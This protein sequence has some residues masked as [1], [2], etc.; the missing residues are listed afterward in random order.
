MAALDSE[1]AV[2][3]AR[4]PTASVPSDIYVRPGPRR[5]RPGLTVPR[6]VAPTPAPLLVKGYLGPAAV[7][8]PRPGN[9]GLG[10]GP[11]RSDSEWQLGLCPG[12]PAASARARAAVGPTE[13]GP[14]ATPSHR[15]TRSRSL[16][17]TGSDW[18]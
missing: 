16:A 4:P 7:T 5:L 14:P 8:E 13:P 17:L 3:V 18:H 6:A 15:A 10:D 9:Y 11:G 2:A 12:Q 1:S